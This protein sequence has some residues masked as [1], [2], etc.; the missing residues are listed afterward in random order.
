M[1]SNSTQYFSGNGDVYFAEKNELGR[2]EGGLVYLGNCKQFTINPQVDR[3]EHRETSSGLGSIDEI[4]E[5]NNRLE[6]SGTFCNFSPENLD[7]YLYGKSMTV[8]AAT[9]TAEAQKAYLGRNILTDKPIGSGLTV[10]DAGGATTYV[11][12]TDYLQRKSNIIYIPN[13]GSAITDAQDV[14]LNYDS[15]EHRN[16]TAF[17]KL[18]TNKYFV[19]DGL[20]RAGSKQKV[21]IEIYKTR[22]DPTAALELINDD[23]AEY[24]LSGMGLYDNCFENDEQFGAFMRVIN[25]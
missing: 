11:A 7:L 21:R 15:P 20:N 9:I 25:I 22:L 12:G 10:T 16:T 6:V 18:N 1:A 8:P 3:K 19:I 4:F 5:D 24:E 17:T 23:F 14:E 13:T 2:P